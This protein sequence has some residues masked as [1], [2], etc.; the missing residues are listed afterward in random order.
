VDAYIAQQPDDT[1]G[2][3]MVAADIATRLTAAGRAEESLAALD[4]V[5]PMK[6][7]GAPFEW[8]QARI[9]AL[10]ALGRAGEAQTY[11][12]TCF[13][14]T[15]SDKHLRAYLKRLP[16]FDD[17]EAE[18]KAFAFVEAVPDI[19][20]ALAFFLRWPALRE[21]AKLVV[22]R[23]TELDG[24]LY[25]LLA[26]AADTLQEKH[27]LAATLVLRSMIDFSLDHS[28]ASRYK[29]A[30]RH[31]SELEILARQITDYGGT[32]T[33]EM[34]LAGIQ[35]IHAKKQNFWRFLLK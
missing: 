4:R 3:P 27:P 10:E 22:R 21:A 8:Q 12:W 35:S 16:D 20:R 17:I 11:R 33:H 23:Q 19:H 32:E 2:S 29:H 25:E 28:R 24:D 13:E 5:D 34:Y 26:A 14:Q 31:M 9:E 1:H 7:A 30:A 18:E 15:L 6:E